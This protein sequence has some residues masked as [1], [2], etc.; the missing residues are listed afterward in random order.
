M[1]G[2]TIYMQEGSN[3]I[4]IHDN[5]VVNLSVDRGTVAVDGAGGLAIRGNCQE[6]EEMDDKARERAAVL[7]EN[8]AFM[9]IMERAVEQ[10]LCSPD[11][12]RFQWSEKIDAV[13]FASVASHKFHLS[14]R[15]DSSGDLSIA[16]KPFEALFGE[17]NFRSKYNDYQQGKIKV[18]HKVEIDGL[19]R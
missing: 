1:A 2:N 4:D 8:A 17:K 9:A 5:E 12:G 14:R 15:H 16:W 7:T 18:H 13:Y 3:Y 6:E 10:G 19:L 11:G